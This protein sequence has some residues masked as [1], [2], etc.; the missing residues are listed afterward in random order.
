MNLKEGFCLFP[1]LILWNK[2]IVISIDNLAGC[3]VFGIYDCII[4][5]EMN[6]DQPRYFIILWY[7]FVGPEEGGKNPPKRWF[8]RKGGKKERNENPIN[9]DVF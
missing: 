3:F 6:D 2:W 5:D 1:S 9:L 8:E 7:W 4:V